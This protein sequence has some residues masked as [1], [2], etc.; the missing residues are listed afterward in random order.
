MKYTSGDLIYLAKMGMFDIIV[1]GCNCF[2]SMGSGIAATIRK[3]FPEAYSVDLATK[4]GDRSKLGTYTSAKVGDLLIVN[5]YTQYNF[6][7]NEFGDLF[8]YESFAEVLHKLAED[9]PT[10]SFGLPK[11]GCGIA[12]GDEAAI[13]KIIE[14][15][16]KKVESTGG[17]VTVVEYAQ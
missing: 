6:S 3:E 14:G 4:P 17:S 7:R 12:H 13:M 11:I 5:A 10:A 8:E 2:N 16:C 15:F 1:H 9:F